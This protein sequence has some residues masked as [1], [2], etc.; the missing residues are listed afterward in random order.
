[1]IQQNPHCR[2]SAVPPQVSP[3]PRFHPRAFISERKN[4]LLGLEFAH[5]A[6]A[7]SFPYDPARHLVSSIQECRSKCGR[8]S[9]A[10]TV[11]N[12]ALKCGSISRDVAP[13][14]ECFPS[15]QEG[16]GSISNSV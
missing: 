10:Y 6:L 14:V 5:T 9:L 15:M 1:M 12:L 4:L 11:Y 13:L 2:K 16:L 8:K 3:S 7:T